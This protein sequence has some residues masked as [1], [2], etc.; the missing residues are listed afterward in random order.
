MSAEQNIKDNTSSKE[1]LS[2][3]SKT[4][5]GDI[6]VQDVHKSFEVTK[7]LDG[8]N[9]SANFGEIHAI[10]G[11]NGC[12]K[13]TLAKVM[14]GVLPIDKGK[15]SVMGHFPTSP[16]M[17]RNLGI[18]T[19]YQEMMIAEEASVVD[20]LF[21]GS[22]SFWYK[23]LTQREKALKAQELMEDL[24]GEHID[25]YTQTFNLSLPIKAWITIGRAILRENIKVLIL[26]E[27]AASLDFDS[28]E[29]LFKKMREFRDSGMAVFIVTHRI[30]ELIRIS[31]KA[32]V[33]LDGKD[34]AVLE[35]KD[36][37][38]KNLLSFMT[39]KAESEEKSKA[40][41]VQTKSDKV[42]IRA[43]DVVVW[44][45]SAPVNLEIRK[46]EILGVTGLDGNGHDDFVKI[47]AGVQESHG[48]TTEVLDINDKFVKYSS[49]IDAKNHGISFVSGDRK[50]EGI[51]A[52]LSIYENLVIPLYRTTSKAGWLGFINW[53]ELNSV[54]DWEVERLNIK[55]G[56]KDNLITSLS[57]GNQQKV[58]IARSFAQHPKVLILNDPA[59]G[60]DVSTKRDLYIHLRKFAEEGNTVIFLSSELE[61][62]I[63]LCPK[64]IV[65]RNGTIFD[66]FENEKVNSD[67]LL[68]GMFGQTAGIGSTS[69]SKSNNMNVSKKTDDTDTYVRNLD[70][71]NKKIINVVY[72]EKEKKSEDKNLDKKIKIKTF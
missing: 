51:L 43:K 27:S 33:M 10:V 35:K 8:V 38:E 61:E 70:T 50:K 7:A 37:N 31:D 69:I 44:P 5:V 25:P 68:H 56:Q 39:V 40:V 42:V 20:N 72:F 26:D 62:F 58:M 28:T 9:F 66:I 67:T 60:I 16:V 52:N 15:V 18:A 14:S 36:L 32:T 64:V 23:N 19:V 49:L 65:F 48:G 11:P 4:V 1:V 6:Y 24:V 46:G 22:D 55:T 71:S 13:S 47:L 57:G 2:K 54:F 41:A 63:G 21:V 17:A 29:R 45:E 34:V 12:G 59:R 3:N 30:A 53:L